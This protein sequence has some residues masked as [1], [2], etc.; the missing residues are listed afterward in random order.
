[1]NLIVDA[2][3]IAFRAHHVYDK[4]QGLKTS[5]GVPT[6]LIYGFLKIVAKWHA[7]HPHHRV[8]VVWDR[9]GGKEW[10]QAIVPSYK[11]NRPSATPPDPG[12][13]ADDLLSGPDVDIFALQVSML[14]DILPSLGIDQISA[15]NQ[16]AD[17][18]IA[19]LVKDLFAGEQNLILTADRDMLQLVTRTD[20]LITPDNKVY[21]ADRVLEEYGVPPER[22]VQLR[23]LIGDKSDNLPGIPRLRKKIAARLVN[24]FG[25]VHSLY[26]QSIEELDLTK[27]EKAKIASHEDLVKKNLEVMNLS[28]TAKSV[29]HLVGSFNENAINTMCATLEFK[30]I[31]KRLL[32][33]NTQQGFLK[34]VLY[35]AD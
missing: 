34:N 24:E 1:M 13:K 10:R 16:E 19:Y 6:G 8:T 12:A 26:D 4:I 11:A 27:N 7:Q 32:D 35:P 17:D 14:H 22:L 5:E 33:F 15:A 30:T 3:N 20:I 31:R 21:D 2:L 18:V 23:A 25:G 9:P 28:A 29:D